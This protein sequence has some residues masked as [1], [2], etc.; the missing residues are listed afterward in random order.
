MENSELPKFYCEKCFYGCKKLSDWNKHISTFKHNDD[1]VYLNEGIEHTYKCKCGKEY[2]YSSGLSKHK[3]KCSVYK[4]NIDLVVENEHSNLDTIKFQQDC[5]MQLIQDNKEFK[6]LLVEFM[7]GGTNNANSHNYNN[8]TNSNNNSFNLQFFL[9]EQCKDA[10][11][12]NEFVNSIQVTIADLEETGRLGYAEGISRIIINNLKQLDVYKRPIHCSDLKRNMLYIRHS[13]AWEKD[14]EKPNLMKSMINN[15]AMKNIG[16]LQNWKN[17]YPGCDA[18]NSNKRETYL[19]I[20]Q[21]AM[22][23][24]SEEEQQDNSMK[25]IKNVAKEVTIDKSKNNV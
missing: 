3:K 15:V 10:I 25:I 9:N 23:G 22:N 6:S 18:Y 21:N 8:N 5:I 1:S 24:S 19:T 7:K 13:N 16:Q 20:V 14:K 17:M 12:I 2:A 4:S 11:D